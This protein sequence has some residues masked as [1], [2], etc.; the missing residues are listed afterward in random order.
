MGEYAFPLLFLITV[1]VAFGLAQ[2]NRRSR[3]CGDC[4]DNCDKSGCDRV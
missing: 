2:R 1:V 3:S 4:D